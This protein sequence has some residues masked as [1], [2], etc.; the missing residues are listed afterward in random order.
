[1]DDCLLY[2]KNKEDI[3]EVVQHLCNQKM[4]LEE[5][6][7]VEGFLGVDISRDD[8][9]GTVTLTQEGLTDRVIEALGISDLP[10]VETPADC[11]L[12]KDEQGDPATG[13][14]NYA[15]VIGMIWYLYGHSRPDLGFAL[16]QAAR[17]THSPRRSHELALIR[18]GQ[19]LK[20]T[21]TQGMI[22]KP[23]SLD[24]IY[25]DCW[26]DADFCGL[27]GKEQRLDPTS[28]KSRTGY[29]IGLNGCPLI[30]SSKLQESI[31]LSTMMAEYYALSSA[32][33]DV[34][35]LRNLT[36]TVAS[37]VG[38]P[39]EHLSTFKITCWEDNAGA[40]TLAN[41]APGQNTPRSKHYDIKMH[42]FRSH[43][44]K[45]IVVKKIDTKEQLADILTKP[46]PADLF[47]AL[48]KMLLGW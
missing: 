13:D 5:E 23:V 34:L 1:V 6:S 3:Q 14:F 42:W 30:W 25:M 7:L 19:Y 37:A 22:L 2:A 45:D 36:H 8:V 10:S 41:L 47:K 17:F 24:H 21:R 40:L 32:M 11:I 31:A 46:L 12:H 35:P 18:I 4:Q 43:L 48:R 33:R 39:P 27:Y 38:I 26:V 15:S 20:G 29:I 44:S 16:S 9:S 28:V